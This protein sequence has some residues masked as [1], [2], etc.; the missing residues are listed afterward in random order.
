MRILVTF[1]GGGG[2]F[3]PL[4]PLARAARRAGHEV[5]FAARPWMVAKV[6][7][8]GFACFPSGTDRGL[9]PVTRPLV[10]VD[11]ERELRDLRDGFGRRIARERAPDL[12]DVCEQWR[13]DVVVWDETDFAAPIVAERLGLPHASFVVIAAGSFVRAEVM[14]EALD[15]LR[16]EHGLAADPTAEMLH[17]QLVLS[18]VPPTFRDPRFAAPATLRS[19]RPWLDGEAPRR[20][21]ADTSAPS[22]AGAVPGAPVVYLTLG[23]V[24]NH[25]SGDLF[26]RAIAG[27]RGLRANIVVTLGREIDPA[28]LGP[29]PSNVSVER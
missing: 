17:R 10:E 12:L 13:P 3:E 4:L 25:E 19:M 11:M 23:T 27:L 22:W 5:A 20:G 9:E 18:P 16:A 7:A 15:E 8:C 2:H 14:A 6:G 26:A 28:S 29:Q 21:R 24:F 1:S